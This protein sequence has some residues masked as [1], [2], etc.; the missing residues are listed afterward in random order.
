[1]RELILLITS[2]QN[3]RQ[4]NGT[5]KISAILNSES[6]KPVYSYLEENQ[7]FW[8]IFKGKVEKD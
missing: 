5:D 8:S 1:M 6:L 3:E 7:N 4:S 2:K